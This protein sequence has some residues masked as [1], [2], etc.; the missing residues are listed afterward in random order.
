VRQAFGGGMPPEAI[1]CPRD[2]T[3]AH[4]VREEGGAMPFYVDVCKKCGGT[5]LDRGE[6]AKLFDSKEAER[7]LGAYASGRSRLRCPRDGTGMAQ[8]PIEGVVIDVCPKCHGMW[9]DRRELE[10]AAAGSREV[11]AQERKGSESPTGR[12]EIDAG[13]TG[14]E[15]RAFLVESLSKATRTQI[16]WNP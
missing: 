5:W 11:V 10:A 9:F 6:F 3:H 2:H 8:R 13:Q 12:A 7:L 14:Q 16:S 15:A 1:R 4:L